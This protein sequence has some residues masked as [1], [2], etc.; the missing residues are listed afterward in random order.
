MRLSTKR[1]GIFVALL[2]L[3]S[4]LAELFISRDPVLPGVK[5][6][7][8]VSPDVLAVTGA[9]ENVK[10]HKLVLYQGI[11]GKDEPYRQYQLAVAGSKGSADVIVRAIRSPAVDS[12]SYKLVSVSR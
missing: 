12:W 1:I 8:A 9:A 4:V 6:F 5:E 2:L 10:V 3:A 11:P 7:V